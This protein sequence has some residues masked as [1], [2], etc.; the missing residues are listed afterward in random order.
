MSVLYPIA[1]PPMPPGPKQIQLVQNFIVAGNDSPFTAQ[2]QTY[3]HQGSWWTAQLDFPPMTRAQASPWLAF[4]ALLNGKSGSFLF[5]DPTVLAPLG[6]AGGTPVVNSAGQTGKT[7]TIANLTGTLKAGDY[8]QIGGENRCL[9]SQAFDNGAW[10]RVNVGA[11]TADTIVAPDGTTTA[12]ALLST[13]SGA[14]VF[15]NL[16][17]PC[18]TPGQ[19][20]A[21]SVWLKAPGG[22]RSFDILVIDSQTSANNV[23]ALTTAWQ[24]F[25]VTFTAQSSLAPKIQIGGSSS[26][27]PNAITIHAWG[28]QVELGSSAALDYFPTTTA[29]QASTRRVHMNLG[30]IA[31]SPCTLDIFPLLRESP[32]ALSESGFLVFAKP[33]GQFKL[34]S[35]AQPYTVDEAGFYSLSFPIREA[36]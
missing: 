3:E 35:N 29:Q 5:G 1:M 33:Q 17:T 15:Q 19:K 18:F 23:C 20:Y 32:I 25:S 8:F 4:L 22:A 7:L 24:R 13:S 34:A 16:P 30:D 9:W 2:R 21:F 12:E 6:S 27:W 26:G 31:G 36:F 28:A 14:S 10:S 11:P